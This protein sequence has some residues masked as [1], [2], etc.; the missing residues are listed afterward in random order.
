MAILKKKIQMFALYC[1]AQVR[2][3]VHGVDTA[4]IMSM[5]VQFTIQ[6]LPD[7]HDNPIVLAKLFTLKPSW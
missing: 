1:I 2:A 5:Q 6:Q 4:V 7:Y 3:G